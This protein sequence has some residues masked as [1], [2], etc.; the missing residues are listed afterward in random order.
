MEN[1]KRIIE[2]LLVLIFMAILLLTCVI[3]LTQNKEENSA[4]SVVSNSYNTNTY[5]TYPDI[6]KNEVVYKYTKPVVYKKFY[7]DEF[8]YSSYGE[9][10]R[11]K[12]FIGTY[13]D[14]F[15]VYVRNQEYEENYFKVKFYFEDYSGEEFDES[16]TRY[17]KAG[18]KEK[19]CF[20]D[21]QEEK[22]K[23][24]DWSYKVFP[25][26]NEEKSQIVYVYD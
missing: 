18:E 3:V 22:Y 23:Y 11:E 26:K 12:D 14:E 21:V 20:K 4:S 8:D 10:S 17:I 15:C 2:L 25:D 6:P 13:V 19:F 1:D 5:N 24:W 16:I 7:Y 9:H